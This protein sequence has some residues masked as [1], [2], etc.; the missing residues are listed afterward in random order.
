MNYYAL[1]PL[2]SS[3]VLIGF[4]A[5]VLALQSS[6]LVS[7]FL[8]FNTT[9][10]IWNLGE[11]LNWTVLPDEMIGSTIKILSVFW[12]LIGLFGLLFAYQLIGRKYDWVIKSLTV[13]IGLTVLLTVTTDLFSA[14]FYQTYWGRVI[15]PGPIYLPV[16]SIT[17][18]LP[19]LYCIYLSLLTLRKKVKDNIS[20]SLKLFAL[21]LSISVVIAGTT[22]LIIP[23]LLKQWD[24]LQLGSCTAVIFCFFMLR[25]I[26]KYKFLQITAEDLAE[27]LFMDSSES[28]VLLN[29]DGSIQKFNPAAHELL[30]IKSSEFSQYDLRSS[31]IDYDPSTEYTGHETKTTDGRY[32]ILSQSRIVNP[33]GMKKGSLLLIQDVSDKK[34]AEQMLREANSRLESEVVRRTAELVT[35]RDFLESIFNTIS[36][37]I[38][39]VNAHGTIIKC[40]RQ[41][42]KFFHYHSAD[43]Q[44]KIIDMLFSDEE[45]IRFRNKLAELKQGG[46]FSLESSVLLQSGEENP[47]AISTSLLTSDGFERSEDQLLVVI[48]D[49]SQRKKAENK[50]QESQR[51]ARMIIENITET[52]LVVQNGLIR[53][54]V[55]QKFTG[56]TFDQV[57]DQPFEQYIHPDYRELVHRNYQDRKN[58]HKNVPTVYQLQIIDVNGRYIWT[59]V[60]IVDTKWEKKDAILVYL[61]DI[62]K[63]KEA[64]ERLMENEK[65]F[66]AFIDQ[67]NDFIM[68]KGRNG[69]YVKINK[70]FSWLIGKEE[71]EIAGK[72]PQDLGYPQN[73]ITD[74]EKIDHQIIE[75]KITLVRETEAKKSKKAGLE[76]LEETMFPILDDNGEVKY[77]GVISRDISETK[78]NEE[79]LSR[80]NEQLQEAYKKLQDSYQII[81]SQEKLASLGTMAAGIAHEINNPSQAIKFSMQSL[82]LNIV[83]LQKFLDVCKQIRESAPDQKE[84]LLENIST[85]ISE[86]D[87]DIVLAELQQIAIDNEKAVDRI[88]NIIQSTSRLSYQDQEMKPC[89]IK[90]VI[91]DALTLLHNNLKYQLKVNKKFGLCIPAVMGIH[92]QLE[93]VL[94]NLINNA[95]DAMLEKG[96]GHNEALLTIQLEYNSSSGMV[97]IHIKDNGSGIPDNV[98]SKI[99]DPFFTTKQLGKGTGLG[100][101]LVHRIITGHNGTISVYSK[102]G[103]GTTF[104]IRLP[105]A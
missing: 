99:Y 23:N 72:T 101:N 35:T 34:N 41:F 31:L 50:L 70:K 60:N 33:L 10:L 76:W 2:L 26:N 53:Y 96:L 52:I 15:K 51:I 25:A 14:G 97:E 49:I 8:A 77:I 4:A 47:V 54:F 90:E 71:A 30:K 3:F 63:Q 68:I 12:Q 79:E 81:I 82:K 7:L 58:G 32:V 22:D 44:N 13:F 38:I 100:L 94:I 95:R 91:N 45:L 28:V 21:G 5:Y 85:A 1:I 88:H 103:E 69:S 19:L 56:H 84:L 64:E 93:Q 39:I 83:D 74:I 48:S 40:N 6:R 37:A 102:I 59:E 62:S 73:F 89:D 105:A 57:K 66:R 80:Q 18:V 27:D 29:E 43:F 98:I 67:A 55:N 9:L 78:R 42:Y 20:K 75:N 92:Q 87:L 36:D 17:V 61:R 24:F 65:L 16:L 46:H 104:I 86:L 11:F